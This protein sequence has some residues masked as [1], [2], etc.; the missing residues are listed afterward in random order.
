VTAGLLGG[1]QCLREQLAQVEHLHAPVTHRGDEV[2]VLPPRA[3]H[4]DEVVEEETLAVVRRKALERSAR[5]VHE[6]RAQLPDLGVC[7]DGV[8]AISSRYVQVYTETS[9]WSRGPPAG[10]VHSGRVRM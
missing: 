8:H 5:P 10:S 1:V 7:P 6:H 3:L 9:R 2:V 4:P